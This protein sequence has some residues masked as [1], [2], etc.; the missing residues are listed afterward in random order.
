MLE[1]KWSITRIFSVRTWHPDLHW[2][3]D[4]HARHH[5]D[6]LRGRHCHSSPHPTGSVHVPTNA[7][8][9]RQLTSHCGEVSHISVSIINYYFIHLTGLQWRPTYIIEFFFRFG[10]F[11]RF[12]FMHL[13]ATNLA[14]WIRTVIWESANEWIHHIYRHKVYNTANDHYRGKKWSNSFCPL[15]RWCPQNQ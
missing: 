15:K 7:L 6:Q 1:C 9:I 10:L 11:A 14:L 2:S 8:P 4:R 3:R 5:G 13:V 12:G